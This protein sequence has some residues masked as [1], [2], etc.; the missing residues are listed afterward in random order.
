LTFVNVDRESGRP[1]PVPEI[2]PETE[3]EKRRYEQALKRRE[4]RVNEE[5]GFI[6]H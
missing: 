5:S 1:I 2:V 6:Q 4:Q 3:E